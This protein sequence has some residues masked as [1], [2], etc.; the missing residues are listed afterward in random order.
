MSVDSEM[1]EG[2]GETECDRAMSEDGDVLCVVNEGLEGVRRGVE[3]R[4]G[5]MVA[6][7]RRQEYHFK[8]S[9]NNITLLSYP[10]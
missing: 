8:R 7:Q 9:K 4:Q 10:I 1:K 5:V 6:A 3:A 2:Y